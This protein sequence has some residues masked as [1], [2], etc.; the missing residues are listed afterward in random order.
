MP[1]TESINIDA[2][3]P[4]NAVKVTDLKFSYGYGAKEKEIFN[5]L[6]LKI[7]RNSRVLLVGD[8]GAGK[9]TLL[10]ILAGKHI[11]AANAVEI[12]GR[13]SFFDN[14]ISRTHLTTEW[15]RTAS[16]FSGSS[17]LQA[18]IAVSEMLNHLQV[19][20]PERRD[21]FVEMLGIDLNWRMHQLSDGQRRRVQI[22]LQLLAPVDLILLDEITTDLDLITRS[23]LLSYLKSLDDVTIIY[24]THIFDGL[25]DWPTHI[26][27]L[28]DGKLTK[29][30]PLTTFD[31]YMSLRKQ[32]VIA[33]LMRT[34]E[35][36]MRHDRKER[37]RK[38]LNV[39]EDAAR[40]DVDELRDEMT[41][42]GY[43]SGRFSMG[44]N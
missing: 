2:E 3:Q 44:Y 11:H 1:K 14:S 25:D 31:D 33:P 24:A 9:S 8:N 26:A 35:S 22:M 41:G 42:N 37:R 15:G 16:G 23:D 32:N 21:M 10:R 34:I 30:G 39:V 5:D 29:Y 20:Y 43:L 40:G 17:P 4:P 6:S 18:D 27:Y 12:F 38:G 28:C 7:E 36:W 19:K 13:E